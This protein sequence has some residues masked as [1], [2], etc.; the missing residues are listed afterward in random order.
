MSGKETDPFTGLQWID[1]LLECFL[2]DHFESRT[3]KTGLIVF[4]IDHSG[5]I[6]ERYGREAVDA[7]VRHVVDVLNGMREM[8]WKMFR[9]SEDQRLE[10]M[11]PTILDEFAIEVL[12]ADPATQEEIARLL[13]KALNDSPFILHSGETRIEEN[14]SLS[15]GHAIFPNVGTDIGELLEKTWKCVL[16]SKESGGGTAIA[17]EE[18]P[19][20]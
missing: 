3:G 2:S 15:V 20:Y 5:D 1:A 6:A 8:N 17:C 11:C 16:R 4:D 10:G 12:D 9:F 19:H 13:N 18:D 7:L 14:V